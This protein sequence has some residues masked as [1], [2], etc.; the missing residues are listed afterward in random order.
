MAPPT[1]MYA[2]YRVYPSLYTI[3]TAF[4]KFE[5]TGM[6]NENEWRRRTCLRS[7]LLDRATS[8]LQRL[9]GPT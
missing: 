6:L 3:R 4:D 1:E 8:L 9:Q 5:K 7:T 2:P